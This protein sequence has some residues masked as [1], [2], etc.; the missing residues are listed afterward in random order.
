MTINN[1]DIST[2]GLKLLKCLGA[3]NLPKTK[4][5][6]IN[7]PDENGILFDETNI[8]KDARN[9]ETEFLLTT[10]NMLLFDYTVKLI[11]NIMLSPGV[12]SVKFDHL[13]KTFSLFVNEQIKVEV[14]TPYDASEIK[15]RIKIQWVEKDPMQAL[16]PIV[17]LATSDYTIIKSTDLFQTQEF[18]GEISYYPAVLH[19]LDNKNLLW[20]ADFG[21]LYSVNPIA[22]LDISGIVGEAGSVN[23]I[24]HLG[25]Q[26]ALSHNGGLLLSQDNGLT[27]SYLWS[28]DFSIGCELV[29]IDE[30][31]IFGGNSLGSFIWDITS[32]EPLLIDDLEILNKN[33]IAKTDNGYIYVC[34][35][36]GVYR[37]TVAYVFSELAWTFITGTEDI[38]NLI[39][40]NGRFIFLRYGVLCYCDNEFI[41]IFELDVPLDT[42]EIVYA[43][44]TN[45]VFCLATENLW[46]SVDNGKNY[47]IIPISGNPMVS[48]TS[49][50]A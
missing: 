2:Y 31:H 11:T 21:F 16:V 7:L 13:N 6:S 12:K 29:F 38:T 35:L 45:T 33:S 19:A 14:L 24:T 8:Y 22:S 37:N 28:R 15:G 32:E 34:T 30:T 27:F 50:P 44:N 20:G 36:S 46:V 41:N 25:T 18:V 17:Y 43:A 5:N 10:A 39:Y 49:I 47:T 26:V 23:K 3:V 42:V 48:I 40:N 9:I 4:Q 1:I